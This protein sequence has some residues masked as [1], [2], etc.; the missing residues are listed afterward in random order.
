MI[1]LPCC[2]HQE[3]WHA[4]DLHLELAKKSLDETG[5]VEVD[6]AHHAYIGAF[7]AADAGE[8]SRAIAGLR[9]AIRQ[10]KALYRP[11]EVKAALARIA[12]LETD[13]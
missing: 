2:A 13:T 5:Y 1:L 8:T 6:L 10:W 11:D 4:W 3:D 12:D 9:L 7:L